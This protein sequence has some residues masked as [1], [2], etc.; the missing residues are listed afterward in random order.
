MAPYAPHVYIYLDTTKPWVKLSHEPVDVI[1]TFLKI[2]ELTPANKNHF[3]EA[4][5][6]LQ[7][8]N[9]FY[10][11]VKTTIVDFD[12]SDRP[13]EDEMQ[14]S[15]WRF[16][17]KKRTFEGREFILYL[18][19]DEVDK[20]LWRYFCAYHMFNNALANKHPL[21]IYLAENV[22]DEPE[23]AFDLLCAKFGIK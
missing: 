10:E 11:L 17:S 2:K 20:L 15:L 18:H 14:K 21:K 13:D 23:G 19:H 8:R 5:R 9:V 3:L 16:S 12:D 1:R 7:L 22:G 6:I 4:D